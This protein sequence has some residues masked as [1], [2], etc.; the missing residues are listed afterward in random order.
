MIKSSLRSKSLSFDSI[1]LLNTSKLRDI[2]LRDSG[3]VVGHR[4]G[5][6][7]GVGMGGTAWQWL[8]AGGSWEILALDGV[9]LDLGGRAGDFALVLA[10]QF[11][12]LGRVLAGSALGNL[13]NV[14]GV[15]SSKIA[16]LRG[17]GVDDL[18][19]VGELLVND[20]LV[21]DVDQGREV[22]NRSGNESKAPGR[23]KL[24]QEVAE[25]SGCESGNGGIDILSENYS[26][27]FNDKEVEQLLKVVGEGIQSLTADSVV[28]A[29]AH[30]RGKASVKDNLAGDFS[31]SGDCMEIRTVCSSGNA[32]GELTSEDEVES[33][34]DVLEDGD[35]AGEEDEG[36]DRG[37]GNG[38]HTRVLPAQ[39]VV[40]H[41]VVVGQGLA[42]SRRLIR[43]FARVQDVSELIGGLVLLVVHSLGCRS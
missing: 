20:T 3:D 39:N 29:W 23:D 41:G 10:N 25:K 4:S 19:C 42:G 35:V 15:V 5:S 43:H 22:D 1:H 11:L 37:V 7:D 36:D 9:G 28:L 38:G 13:G 26:L 14:I 12:S 40:E 27:E 30:V 33:L 17:L 6:D 8:S 34:E 16:E 24:D 32:A 18:A 21:L 31:G 2:V